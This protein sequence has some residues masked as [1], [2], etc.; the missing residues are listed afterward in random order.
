MLLTTKN[1]NTC[2]SAVIIV[3]AVK[4][5]QYPHP[6]YSVH[7]MAQTI[8]PKYQWKSCVNHTK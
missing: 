5:A 1:F 3:A 7:M 8:K 2:G 6:S 4:Y